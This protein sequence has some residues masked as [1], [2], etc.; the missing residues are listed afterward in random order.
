MSAPKKK[1][2]SALKARLA[3]KAAASVDVPPPGQVVTPPAPE[4]EPA[5]PAPADL[6]PPGQSMPADIPAPGQVAPEPEPAPAYEEPAP[7]YQEP[8]AAAPAAALSADGDIYSGGAAFDPNDGIIADDGAGVPSRSS[9]G[10]ALTALAGGVLVGALLGYFGNEVVSKNKM[11]DAATAKAKTM[12]AEVERVKETR[13]KISLQF[14]DVVKTI[15]KD[16]AK[17]ANELAELLVASFGPESDFPKVE[18]LFGWQLASLHPSSVKKAFAL[19]KASQ[20]L[21]VDMGFMAQYVSANAKVINGRGPK[22][23]AVVMKDGGAVLV[24]MAGF[25]CGEGEEAKACEAGKEKDATAMIIRETPGGPTGPVS[26]EAAFPLQPQ[27]AI[28][29]Y[30]IGD[31]PEQNAANLYKGLAKRVQDRLDAMAKYEKATLSALAKYGDNPTTD[32]ESAQPDP[33]E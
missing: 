22:S 9:T 30:A 33:G 25:M 10:L 14:E 1:D 23:Y 31:H 13:T 16:P 29:Q 19:Y 3:K 7:A 20:D 6:P 15:D 21:V 11:K 28:Y 18:S 2:L 8:A 17:G 12:L 27:G 4:P 32:D 5:A 26:L 24:E